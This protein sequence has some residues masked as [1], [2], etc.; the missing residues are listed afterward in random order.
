M[1]RDKSIEKAKNRKLESMIDKEDMSYQF[2][3]EQD[4][5]KFS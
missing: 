2:R 1:H 4:K 5:V 3:E